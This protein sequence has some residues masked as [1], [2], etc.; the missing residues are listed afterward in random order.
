MSAVGD[1]YE[2][3]TASDAY[4]SGR[5][6]KATVIAHLC[7]PYLTG[8]ARV[9]DLGAGTGIIRKALEMTTGN[10]IFGMEIDASFIVERERMT[11][12]D[13]LCLPLADQCVDVA[14]LNHL[15]EH[16]PNPAVLFEETYR[17]LRPGGV[18]YV[19]AGSRLAIVEPHYRLPF[20]SWLP[21]DAASA[22]LRWTRRGTAYDDIQFLTYRPLAKLM[23]SAG[24]F[25]HDIT[26]RAI[27][28]LIAQ[29]WGRGWSLLWRG[30]RRTPDQARRELLR[31]WSPQWFFL[32]ERPAWP[33]VESSIPVE[34]T[35]S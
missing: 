23:R 10:P 9:I 7:G 34:A 29:A 8:D 16:V 30:L 2:R 20:L 4:R 14:I 5:L 25:V 3:F 22:Y 6:R 35:G 1:R 28:D 11:Q 17:V 33:G 21:N 26:E 31:T 18:A 19:A 32:L 15:Y 13:V 12:A 24:F 27:D